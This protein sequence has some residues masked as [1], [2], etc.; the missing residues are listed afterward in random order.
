MIS[1]L[2]TL[3]VPLTEEQ[4]LT[5][6][7]VLQLI[8]LALHPLQHGN[9]YNLKPALQQALLVTEKVAEDALFSLGLMVDDAVED[10]QGCIS[11]ILDHAR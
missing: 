7:D 10:I 1:I 9:D 4:C 8:A 5:Y 2:R 11:M 3:V 6:W